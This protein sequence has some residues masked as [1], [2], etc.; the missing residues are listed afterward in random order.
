MIYLRKPLNNIN[1]TKSKN[2]ICSQVHK[3]GIKLIDQPDQSH[4]HTILFE[5]K[6]PL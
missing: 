4:Q 1:D 3:T 6:L 2:V 5:I